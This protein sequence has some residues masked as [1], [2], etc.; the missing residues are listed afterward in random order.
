MHD[1]RSPG[2]KIPPTGREMPPHTNKSRVLQCRQDV[3][4][5]FCEHTNQLARIHRARRPGASLKY[6]RA[7]QAAREIYRARERKKRVASAVP[8]AALN[9]STRDASNVRQRSERKMGSRTIPTAGILAGEIMVRIKQ[10]LG[11]VCVSRA[12]ASTGPKRKEKEPVDN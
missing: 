9:L 3:A 7:L 5:L 1:S 4:Y 2:R 10:A 6:K 12:T 8:W 11:A